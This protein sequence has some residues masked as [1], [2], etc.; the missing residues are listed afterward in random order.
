[1]TS[2]DYNLE[3]ATL[4]PADLIRSSYKYRWYLTLEEVGALVSIGVR[5]VNRLVQDKLIPPPI[6]PFNKKTPLWIKHEFFGF[7]RD[8][9]LMA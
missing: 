8:K 6:R 1:M 5:E 3:I 4:S 7:L 9:G 2:A